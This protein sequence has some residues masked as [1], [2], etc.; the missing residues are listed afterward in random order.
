MTGMVCTSPSFPSPLASLSNRLVSLSGQPIR[1]GKWNALVTKQRA[2]STNTAMTLPSMPFAVA[3]PISRRSTLK[4]QRCDHWDAVSDI[5]LLSFPPL[6]LRLDCAGMILFGIDAEKGPMLYKTDPA[7][8]FCGFRATSAGV[9]QTE[10]NNFLEKRMKKKADLN[11]DEAIEVTA[12]PVAP[13]FE[14]VRCRR[15]SWPCR[16]WPAFCPRI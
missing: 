14:P 3:L 9:K 1:V 6:A 7:G 11:Y 4:K 8:Y 10:A 15:S 5:C 16:R 2:G 13:P 12:H